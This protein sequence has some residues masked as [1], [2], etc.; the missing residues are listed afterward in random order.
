MFDFIKRV[1][2]ETTGGTGEGG[3]GAGTPPPSGS[4]TPPPSGAGATPPAPFYAGFQDTELRGYIETKGF[5][6]PQDLALSYKNLEKLVGVP[7][8]QVLRLPKEGDTEGWNKLHERLGRPAK[9]EEYELPLPPGANDKYA[10][11]I[12]NKMHTLGVSKKVA[13]ELAAAQ[14]E[15]VAAE[16]A[17]NATAYQ[18]TIKEQD[19]ALRSKWGQAYD[20]NLQ[21]AKGAF[22]ELGITTEAVNALEKAM[23]FAGVMEFFHGLGAKIGE[24]RFVSAAGTPGFNGVMSPAAAQAR[25]QA[26]AKDPVLSVKY[27]NGD[28]ALKAEMDNLHRMLSQTA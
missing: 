11:F 18:A 6:E 14:N 9:P 1:L 8:D 15:F 7:A 16:A 25:I 4:G 2:M 21:V 28:A 12:A 17:E 26:I 22:A 5:K 24:D 20:K 19:T 27:A 23:G 3:A 10:K 13:Q